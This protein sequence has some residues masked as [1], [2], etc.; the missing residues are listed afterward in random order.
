MATRNPTVWVTLQANDASVLI[1][2]YVDTFGLV[3]AARYD[4][5][6][7]VDHAQLNW[8]E[9][10][11]GVMLGS[12][13]PG[14]AW[15]REPGTMGCYVVTSDPDALYERVL[16]R[17]ADIVRPLAGT[18]YGAREFAVR[19]PEGNLWSFGDYPGEPSREG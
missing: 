19:D 5:D 1:D 12:H 18:D 13:R 11:G 8:P 6:G 7:T 2:Y 15:S 3:L 9:G 16:G 17:G 10:S 14:R 4:G